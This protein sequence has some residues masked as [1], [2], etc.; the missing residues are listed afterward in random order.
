MQSPSTRE[1]IAIS[2]NWMSKRSKVLGRII[3]S[4]GYQLGRLSSGGDFGFR[5]YRDNSQGARE[6]I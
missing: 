5:F 4:W 3:P 6:I 2:C 1:R